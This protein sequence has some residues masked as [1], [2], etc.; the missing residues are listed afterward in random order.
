MKNIF[1]ILLFF[2]FLLLNSSLTE[3][4]TL[5]NSPFISKDPISFTKFTTSNL[6]T[7]IFKSNLSFDFYNGSIFSYCFFENQIGRLGFGVEYY[8][9]SLRD[10]FISTNLN[11]SVKPVNYSLFFAKNFDRINAGGG[12][13][14]YY[15]DEYYNDLNSP[16]S[17]TKISFSDIKFS[18]SLSFLLINDLDID[19][20]GNL[21]F[22]SVGSENLSNIV[23]TSN[24]FGY[25]VDLRIKQNFIENFVGFLLNYKNKTFGYQVIEIGNVSGDVYLDEVD[26]LNLTIFAGI[27]S[28]NYHSTYIS[29]EY[30]KITYHSRTIYFSSAEVNS[31]KTVTYFPKFSIGSN[32]YLTNFLDLNV[33]FTGYLKDVVDYLSPE[34]NPSIKNSNFYYDGKIGFT[35]K[36]ENLKISLDFSKN[37]INIPFIISGKEIDNI[38]VNFGLSYSGYE[39]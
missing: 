21:T 5:Q 26:T 35:F 39:Y 25:G 24:P 28:F 30:Q 1:F 10:K 36:V 13:K 17:N 19:V 16:F 37:L 12:V 33:G 8:E 3:W 2:L 34:L 23:K 14:F 20:T 11:K 29:G 15:F 27:E 22:L 9:D 6:E 4:A 7:E 18:P 38:S 32:F 31:K